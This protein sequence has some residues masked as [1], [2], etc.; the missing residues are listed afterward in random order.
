MK[1]QQPEHLKHDESEALLKGALVRWS[2][3]IAGDIDQSEH[4]GWCRLSCGSE[5]EE[6]DG[7]AVRGDTY[8]DPCAL[9]A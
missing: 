6:A 1:C 8:E 2:A 7:E 9:D 3:S 5:A 4:K